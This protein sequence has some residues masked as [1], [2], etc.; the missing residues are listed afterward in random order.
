MLFFNYSKQDRMQIFEGISFSQATKNTKRNKWLLQV[1]FVQKDVCMRLTY[2]CKGDDARNMMHKID[3][4]CFFTT[5]T[6]IQ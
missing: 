5:N 3:G 4:F 6:Y 2:T 1:G